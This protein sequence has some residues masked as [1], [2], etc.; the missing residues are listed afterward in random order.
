MEVLIRVF[1]CK[2]VL[3]CLLREKH[4]RDKERLVSRVCTKDV[5]TAIEL[6]NDP[7][8][9]SRAAG[10]VRILFC[11]ILTDGRYSESN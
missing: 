3:V 6:W 8:T 10:F 11:S 7:F 1:G 4:R 2:E 9:S 5:T